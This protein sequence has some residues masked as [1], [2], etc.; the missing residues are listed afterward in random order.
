M[1]GPLHRLPEFSVHGANGQEG[2]NVL[3]AAEIGLEEQA[4]ATAEAA[5]KCGA[6]FIDVGTSIRTCARQMRRNL[7]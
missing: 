5:N 3:V 4:H 7:T 6:E 2:Q 1:T